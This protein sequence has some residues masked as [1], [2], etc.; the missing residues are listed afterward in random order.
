MY[1]RKNLQDIIRNLK[2]SEATKDQIVH[3][4][5]IEEKEASTVPL[6]AN[7]H[8]SFKKALEQRGIGN[9]Y[10]HQSSAYLTVQ[11][12][13]SIV[14]VTP[15]ASGKTVPNYIDIHGHNLLCLRVLRNDSQ[16]AS[17]TELLAKLRQ[18]I[19]PQSQN[20]NI[21]TVRVYLNQ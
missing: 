18:G 14:A 2:E 5:T 20:G 21:H 8:T 3:W 13:E 11:K 15:T 19:T 1:Q 9:I 10:T 12:G 17:R 7:L 16:H 4:H 6:P